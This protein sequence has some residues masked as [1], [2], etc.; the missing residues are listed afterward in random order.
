[1]KVV[2]NP[3]IQTSITAHAMRGTIM[4]L[5]CIL[6][7]KFL[8]FHLQDKH[9]ASIK[10][11]WRTKSENKNREKWRIAIGLHKKNL[12]S[13]LSSPPKKQSKCVAFDKGCVRRG[14]I[15][16]MLQ[17]KIRVGADV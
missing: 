12:L 15:G 10:R 17:D 4:T 2:G 3:R 14:G 7:E 8:R 11:T 13:G 1:M 5:S 16:A 9:N 6:N